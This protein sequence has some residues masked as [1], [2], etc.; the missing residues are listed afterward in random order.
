MDNITGTVWGMCRETS[1]RPCNVAVNCV[2][3]LHGV[4][5]LCFGLQV[6]HICPLLWYYAAFSGNSL[7]TFR[8]KVSAPSSRDSRPLKI[9]LI[10]CPETSVRSYNYTL[11]NIPE[12]RRSPCTVSFDNKQRSYTEHWWTGKPQTLGEKPA[13]CHHKCYND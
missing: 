12:E 2:P 1:G 4:A 3:A 5:I 10:S 6:Y 8:D 7:P 11:R 13:H 9:A